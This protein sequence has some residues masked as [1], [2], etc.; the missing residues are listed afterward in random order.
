MLSGNLSK[1]CVVRPFLMSADL[2]ADRVRLL[3]AAAGVLRV[4]HGVRLAAVDSSEA[5]SGAGGEASDVDAV[6]ALSTKAVPASTIICLLDMLPELP[7]MVS[8]LHTAAELP[9][10]VTQAD[11]TRMGAT[12]G[13]PMSWSRWLRLAMRAARA[14]KT[15][16]GLVG[17]ATKALLNLGEA[18]A[19]SRA[20]R[21]RSHRFRRFCS[22]D[23]S[24]EKSPRCRTCVGPSPPGFDLKSLHRD[25]AAVLIAV[26]VQ[27]RHTDAGGPRHTRRGPPRASRRPAY[28]RR[29]RGPN[30]A[31]PG[32]SGPDPYG[33]A[34]SAA[35]VPR[36]LEAGA[37]AAA[38]T[39][40]TPGPA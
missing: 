9:A 10:A 32:W 33:R 21:S 8:G 14:G 26:R 16:V 29:P 27:T 24:S 5:A 6:V 11:I 22:T 23:L 15:L 4:Q 17:D 40:G 20:G 13:A 31:W 1:K 37:G 36:P 18:T 25:G 35:R 12:V 34:G 38:P 7:V 30:G 28:R 3:E 39:S 19:R 2:R